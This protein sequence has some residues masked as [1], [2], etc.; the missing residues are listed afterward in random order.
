MESSSTVTKFRFRESENSNDSD[1]SS[2]SISSFYSDN[3]DQVS[4]LQSMAGKG[5][6]R[7][8]AE[9]LEIKALSDEDFHGNIFANYSAFLGVFDEVKDMEKE[10]MK[11][12]TQVST[13]KGLVKE[14]V[15]GAYLKL[16]SEET[17]ESIIE[18]SE[19][20]EPPRELEDRID[21]VSEILD[22]L[23]SENRIDEAIGILEMEEENLQR[24]V[25]ELGDTASDVLMLYKSV[26]SER[27]AMLTMELTL[28]TEN[29]RI[30]AP[31]LQKALV[32]ICRLGEGHLAT[33]LLLKYYHSRIASGIHD[34]QNSKAFLHVVYVREL[35]RSFM[36][37]FGET[38][39]FASEF[40][41][42]V[43]EEME[44][45]AVSFAKHVMSV[46]EVSSRLSTA[47]ESA[48]FALSYC[49]LSESQ[50]LV[51]RPCL[52]EH[53]S[54]C[55]EEVLR[56]HVEDFK[57][58]IGIF[59]E[60]DAWVLGRYLLSGI[61]NESYSSMVV[62]ERPEYCRLTSSGRKFVTVLQAITGDVTPLV[63]L[64]LEDSIFRGLMNLFSEYIAILER[65][66][67]SETNES[68]RNGSGIILAETVP[69]QVSILANLSTLENLFSS[70]ILS[71]FGS[72]NHISSEQMK[73]QSV[74]FHHQ[75]LE[76]RVSF[77]Q[78]ASARLRAH[79]FQ[80]FICRMMSPE[81][82]CKLSPQKFMDRSQGDP[83]VV[84]GAVPSVAFQ[85]LFL[86]LRKLGKLTEDDVFEVDWL[87]ELLRELIEA[88][89]VWISNDKEIWE[90]NEE[91]L[92]FQ[93]PDI[94]NQLDHL[95]SFALFTADQLHQLALL[96]SVLRIQSNATR[97]FLSFVLDTHFLVET[98]RYGEYFTNPM[99]PATL[100]NSVFNSAGLDPTRDADDDDDGGG[101]WVMK[102][103]V[104]AIE[105]LLE[106]EET[107]SPSDD[108]LVGISVDEPHENP[109]EHAS[110]TPNDEGTIFSEDCLM[111]DENVAT[112]D[113][114][115]VAVHLG[116]T[117]LNAELNQAGQFPDHL[118][119]KGCSID[120]STTCLNDISGEIE[121]IESGNA[122]YDKFHFDQ[123]TTLPNLLLSVTASEASGVGSKSS[124]DTFFNE[125]SHIIDRKAKTK[126]GGAKLLNPIRKKGQKGNPT[127]STLHPRP[128]SSAANNP[129]LVEATV[130]AP[131]SCLTK[132]A[133]SGSERC[134]LCKVQY[135]GRDLRCLPFI[136]N[137][138]TIYR[139][140]DAAFSTGILQSLSDTGRIL[141]Q[142]PASTS[143]DCKDKKL[144]EAPWENNSCSGR[145]KL[146]SNNLAHVP[147]N[148]SV[149]IGVRNNEVTDNC[150]VPMH[151]KDKEHGMIGS[152]GDASN[153]KQNFDSPQV[154]SQ[155]RA[156]RLHESKSFQMDMNQADQA[157]PRSPPSFGD[158]DSENDSNDQGGDDSPQN[159]KA[160]H[161]VRLNSDNRRRQERHDCSASETE[162]GHLRDSKRH[163]NLNYNPSGLC[164]N[165]IGH[166]EP[167]TPQTE[168]LIT[169][170]Q[171]QS[172]ATLNNSFEEKTAC[173]F[174]LS[175]RITENTGPMLHYANG[176]QVVGV[177]ATLSNTIHVHAICI[178]WAPQVYYVGDTVKNLKAE[179]A[180]GA[181]LKC[182]KCGLKG[183]ALGCYLKS[184]KRSYHA[185]CAMEITKCRWDLENF[186]VLCPAHSSVKFPNEKSKSEK[187]NIKISS[188]PTSVAPSQSNFWAGS[189]S[190]AKEW[191]FCG[192]ALS[193][194]E[195][196]S[197]DD[198]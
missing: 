22:S 106:I 104:E 6:K 180:R 82:G 52:I 126:N 65:A 99:V 84:H 155:I 113:A 35:S 1:T 81:T 178:E 156:R 27:K 75:E 92:N 121:D 152:G 41:Q 175:S 44:V 83:G 185:P 4:D 20:D 144:L 47:V 115:E 36:K 103:A 86:E 139:S 112:T 194:E 80:Q 164:A 171:L 34:L 114:L 33:Q 13:Q 124:P 102:A 78:D 77:V 191:V 183:A 66:I 142:S 11:L 71:V 167:N 148:R 132:T 119:D 32:G 161:L 118:K 79:F 45:F 93:H 127:P 39:P 97:Q 88:I 157:S 3:G 38:S 5:I 179:L 2:S 141:K 67:T 195:K 158:K 196:V 90:N 53:I 176:K 153:I 14:L 116:N 23:L 105:K 134:P 16:L 91:Q 70:T 159:Y 111:L 63:A 26:I 25:V 29:S 21:D 28:V 147:L 163:K 37:L 69:Q 68:K 182:A 59:T 143:T 60:T 30:S 193:S 177:E 61:L 149:E 24:V 136:E 87:M 160:E 197:L 135:G 137:M 130:F 54:P 46:S 110:E 138:V 168:N 7:L 154:G 174:C 166:I 109:S 184:C 74:G 151:V 140:L 188:V 101:G 181:K 85:V 162:K 9:L 31:E 50:R 123:E 95:T 172:P 64:Q 18:E 133:E 72:N 190:G 73:N 98:I 129:G 165:N 58:V 89:F 189:S 76:S 198:G 15:D 8:C 117:N 57:K 169:S 49:S 43:N 146:M 55:M 120:S 187:H 128:L 170:S 48:Q 40:I 125:S 10:L 96:L 150:N 42:W 145:S 19:F 108:E 17:M 131:F 62:G 100:M 107:D 122:A 192:S 56:I 94:Q 186:L 51:L 173:G 12:K